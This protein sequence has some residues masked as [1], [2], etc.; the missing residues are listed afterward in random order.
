MGQYVG[1]SS[2]T[3]SLQEGVDQ[4]LVVLFLERC[5][6]QTYLGVIRQSFGVKRDIPITSR[7]GGVLHADAQHPPGN[8]CS[9]IPLLHE[10]TNSVIEHTLSILLAHPHTFP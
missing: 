10:L 5:V 2:A 8:D 6:E 9:G 4:D 1:S 7:H 3:T